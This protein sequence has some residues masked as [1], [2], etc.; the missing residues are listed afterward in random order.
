MKKII[1]MISI[2]VIVIAGANH[3]GLTKLLTDVSRLQALIAGSGW[4]GYAL[5]IGL[6]VFTSI[7]LLPGQF[8]AVVGGICWGGFVGG[9]L[10]V[11]GAS[12]GCW[13]SFVIGRYVARDYI[14]D[15]MGENPTFRKIERGVRENGTTFLVFTRLVPI[16]PF[17]IQ[18][19]AYALT[20]M[21]AR[22]FS[23]ISFFTMMPACF[24]YSY[25]AA[26][27]ASDGISWWILLDLA[28]AGIVLAGLTLLP[29]LVSKRLRYLAREYGEG[30]E[31]GAPE[32]HSKAPKI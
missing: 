4:W 12:V 7:F 2:M 28:I 5:F 32:H 25:L 1:G 3:F 11:I 14:V 22:K 27:V 20:P 15:H 16:F 17:A 23:V 26:Q 18:S 21:T 6:S 31:K 8:L 24:I 9:M 30:T 19:Y 29:K 13:V 10:T